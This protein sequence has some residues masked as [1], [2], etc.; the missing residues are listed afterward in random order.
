MISLSTSIHFIFFSVWDLKE[1]KSLESSI[2]KETNNSSIALCLVT[3]QVHSYNYACN[4][5]VN[6]YGYV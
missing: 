1:A 4:V 3:V 2:Y 6:V 5:G